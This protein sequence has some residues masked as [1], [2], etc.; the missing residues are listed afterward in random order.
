MI[1]TRVDPAKGE[2]DGKDSAG[3]QVRI[4]AQHRPKGVGLPDVGEAW[5]VKRRGTGWVLVEQINAEPPLSASSGDAVD[6]MM[7]LRQAGLV[8]G[9]VIDNSKTLL[10]WRVRRAQVGV[11]KNVAVLTDRY[12]TSSLRGTTWGDL[13]QE[14]LRSQGGGYTVLGATYS[15]VTTPV[16][17]APTPPANYSI[18]RWG[19]RGEVLLFGTTV[20]GATITMP[21]PEGVDEVE[22]TFFASGT[23][24]SFGTR[25]NTGALLTSTTVSASDNLTR[26]RVA[27]GAGAN[28]LA[29]RALSPS[30][31]AFVE[32]ESVRFYRGDRIDGTW[33]DLFGQWDSNTHGF[34]RSEHPIW[35]GDSVSRAS[36]V[37]LALGSRDAADG[38]S[39][40]LFAQDIATL[41]D[42]ILDQGGLPM[43]VVP[44]RPWGVEETT[45]SSFRDV[46]YDSADLYKVGLIDIEKVWP[47]YSEQSLGLRNGV[48]LT[49]YGH[50]FIA[51]FVADSLSFR[52]R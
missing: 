18:G 44:P 43:V 32:V 5:R 29:L 24:V 41:L 30:A 14:A 15:S 46:M 16:D 23:S 28:T 10:M 49:D 22:A 52:V 17:Y 51:D 6:P 12:L 40:D 13:L 26:A 50:A 11:P 38:S 9:R 36:L 3:G 48:E 37:L 4:S 2:V 7:V 42:R 19:S 45:W 21:I 8:S 34:A 47:N 35:R 27:V 1:V 20:V 39:V 31:T 33:V 25:I